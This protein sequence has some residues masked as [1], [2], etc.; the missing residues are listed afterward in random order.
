M[1]FKFSL[2]KNFWVNPNNFY[3]VSGTSSGLQSVVESTFKLLKSVPIRR[4]LQKS[5]P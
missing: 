2:R 1:I 3:S 4:V 5:V